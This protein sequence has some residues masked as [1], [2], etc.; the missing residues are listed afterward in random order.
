MVITVLGPKR[1]PKGA[2]RGSI[3]GGKIN[4][5]SHQN[6]NAILVMFF[7]VPAH[8]PRQK[9]CIFIGALFK[10]EGR[11]FCAQAPPRSFLGAILAP[12]IVPKS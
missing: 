7:G 11:P 9:S 10:I 4:T 8:A 6:F 5:N 12:K 1:V 2:P 3:L